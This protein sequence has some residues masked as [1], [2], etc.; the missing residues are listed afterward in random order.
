MDPSE[1]Q[2]AIPGCQAITTM[3]ENEYQLELA[4]GVGSV[5]GVFL[6]NIAIRNMNP[7]ISYEMEVDSTGKAGFVRGV[8][9]IRLE[10]DGDQTRVIYEG[11]VQVGG[12]IASVGQ[13]MIQAVSKKLSNDF[14]E[15]LKSSL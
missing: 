10:P 7:P 11:N 3:G 5:K 1:L 13:R 9:Y 12:A 4:V 2:R 14:F 8:G 6:G 15:A